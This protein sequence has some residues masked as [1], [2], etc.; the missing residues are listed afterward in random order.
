MNV[1]WFYPLLTYRFFLPDGFKRIKI[2]DKLYDFEI[3]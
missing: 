1:E 2:R 3:F